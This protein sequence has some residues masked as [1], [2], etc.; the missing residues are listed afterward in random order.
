MNRHDRRGAQKRG[1]VNRESTLEYLLDLASDYA[2]EVLIEKRGQLAESFFLMGPDESRPNI[3]TVTMLQLH[4]D[5]QR[6]ECLEHIRHR[7]REVGA[8][9]FGHVALGWC[10]RPLEPGA[11]NSQFQ[12]SQRPCGEDRIIVTADDSVSVRVRMWTVCKNETGV[13]TKLEL[14]EH[15]ISPRTVH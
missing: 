13:A 14:I 8:V 10:A 2:R 12:P 6:E 7:M 3:W 15:G 4:D 1:L 5:L 9:A 11:P